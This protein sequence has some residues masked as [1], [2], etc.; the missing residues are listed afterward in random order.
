MATK[1]LLLGLLRQK[2]KADPSLA[3]RMTRKWCLRML[4]KTIRM[5]GRR[6]KHQDDGKRLQRDFR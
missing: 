5:G 2:R 6:V 4:S 1:D 3:L